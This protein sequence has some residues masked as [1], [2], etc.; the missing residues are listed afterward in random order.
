MANTLSFG[1]VSTLL[2]QIVSQATGKEQITPTNSYEFVAVAQTGLLAG[3]DPIINSIS[4][5]LAR[6]LFSVRPY[7]R[8]FRGLEVSEQ[9][10]GNQVRKI[11]YGDQGREDDQRLT[12]VDGQ[13]VDHYRVNK[14]PI[15]QTNWYGFEQFQFHRTIF[16]DQLDAAFSS[17]EEF[18][19]F[20]SGIM[21]NISDMFEQDAENMARATLGNLI[22]ATVRGYNR[23]IHLLSEYNDIAD[24]TL[25]ASTVYKPEN[26][27]TFM[28]WAYGRIAEVS[29]K[30]EER[31][32]LYQAN[33]V[34][35]NVMRHTPKA[36]QRMFLYNP[37][38]LH[39]DSSVL[40][41]VFNPE[42]LSANITE[43]V[44][45]WQSIKTPDKLSLD[46]SYMLEADGT[47]AKTGEVEVDNIFGVIIDEN[48]AG[49]TQ[50]STWTHATPFN[51]A[52][53]FTNI[54]WHFTF[55]YWNDNTEKCAVF[56]LD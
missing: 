12:L 19:R 26:F 42:F 55:R 46:A 25:T 44:N 37:A 9:M 23:A 15:L 29:S 32:N 39:M 21:Q 54:F 8:K 51:A 22:V 50:A 47:V 38:S 40:S 2:N 52:G 45:F 1:Q 17:A 14:P 41:S 30:M 18:G 33:I 7:S 34:G 4:Q 27:T 43:R 31:T 5:V 24:T 16:K 28:R 53:G 49:Y 36:M 35:K 56:L 6:T 20:I 10:Y 48:A 3:Y 11:S 13:S